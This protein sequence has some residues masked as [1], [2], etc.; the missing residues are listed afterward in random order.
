MGSQYFDFQ[1]ENQPKIFK[2]AFQPNDFISSILGTLHY[3]LYR[4]QSRVQLV[5]L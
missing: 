2:I 5:E 3:A 1:F 4:L